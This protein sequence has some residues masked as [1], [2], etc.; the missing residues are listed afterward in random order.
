MTIRYTAL[1]RA[2]AEELKKIYDM[3]MKQEIGI[4]DAQDNPGFLRQW[5]DIEGNMFVERE[6]GKPGDEYYFY[7]FYLQAKKGEPL[8]FSY[9]GPPHP[10]H[11]REKAEDLKIMLRMVMVDSFTDD[12]HIAHTWKDEMGNFWIETISRLEP[13]EDSYS[14][15]MKK[16]QPE[17][18][19]ET[20]G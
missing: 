12:T 14:F 17:K 11:I 16:R 8:I 18:E 10:I 13:P 7:T 19:A 20:N 1:E 9:P 3:T 2:Q 6:I 15:A 4:Q 5:I